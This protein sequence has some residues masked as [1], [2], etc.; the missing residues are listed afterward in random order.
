MEK[1]IKLLEPKI[2]GEF[3]KTCKERISYRQYED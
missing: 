3:L 2:E 1:N